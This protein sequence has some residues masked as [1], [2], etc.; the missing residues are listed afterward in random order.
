MK[1]VIIIAIAFVLL[2]P[3][4]VFAQPTDRCANLNPGALL[5]NCDLHGM[6]LSKENLSGAD[7]RGA[8]LSDADL[9]D[10]N[11]YS[12]NFAGVDTNNTIGLEDAVYNENSMENNKNDYTKNSDESQT[13]SLAKVK[14]GIGTMLKDGQCIVDTNYKTPEPTSEG[15]I[16]LGS[17]L[18]KFVQDLPTYLHYWDNIAGKNVPY[19]IKI[20]DAGFLSG[21]SVEMYANID[22]PL[23]T[24]C[25][26]TVTSSGNSNPECLKSTAKYVERLAGTFT[27]IEF[28]STN[29]ALNYFNQKNSSDV[30]LPWTACVSQES[31]SEQKITC[32]YFNYVLTLHQHDFYPT[33]HYKAIPKD[34]QEN[35]EILNNVIEKISNDLE[36]AELLEI[37]SFVKSSKISKIDEQKVI[38]GKTTSLLV[39]DVSITNNGKNSIFLNSYYAFDYKLNKFSQIYSQKFTFPKCEGLTTAEDY[40]NKFFAALASEK[41]D[42]KK[43]VEFNDPS[44]K[45]DENCEKYTSSI[46]PNETINQKIC[47]E[48]GKN[49][50][51]LIVTESNNAY[52]IDLDEVMFINI[53]AS[54]YNPETIDSMSS[55]P[56]TECGPG[57]VLKDDVCVLDE[58]CG[59]GTVLEDGVCVLNNP[60]TEPSSKGGGCLIATATYGSEMASEVQQLRELRDNTLLNTESGSIFMES[61]NDFYY[62]FSP[63][64][65]DY[66][67]ENP[68]FK[69]MVKIAITP[70]ISSLSILNYVD[71]DSEA[72]VLGYGISLILLNLGMYLGIPAVVII[73]IR[74]I[75]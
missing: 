74:K 16:Q 2:I 66:E 10:A 1:P 6:Y 58:R 71:M 57:T 25:S 13:N 29:N 14:C 4:T 15:G 22:N 24:Q 53:L 46:I 42:F 70:M 28:D 67:R 5:M 8:D 64:I 37:S 65:A 34:L 68:V 9:S 31:L 17:N 43:S 7:L 56:K 47:I 41:C 51:P 40:K 69:E 49:S 38:D 18:S 30:K 12:T 52:E 73:S 45:F 72:E 60:D 20:Q 32:S 62:S 3:T 59:P 39:L 48:I 61:F 33:L 75:K 19:Q 36:S 55:T 44:F 54:G 63:I 35:F 21:I 50:N 26:Q 23:I 27:I 11:I